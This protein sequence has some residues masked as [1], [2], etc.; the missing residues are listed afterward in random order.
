[1]AAQPDLAE[2]AD[3]NYVGSYR[4]LVEHSVAGAI[5][6]F[7]A[8]T[9]FTTGLPIGIFNGCIVVGPAEPA[10]LADSVR[11][12]A[13]LGVPYRVWIR[14]ELAG[15]LAPIPLGLGL[16]REAALYPGMVLRPAPVPPSPAPGVTVGPVVGRAALEEHLEVHVR[17]GLS[18]ELAK[19]MFSTAF[20]AD[21]DVRLFTAYLDGRPAGTSLAIRTGDASGV[22]NVGTLP[23]AR[24]RGV[25]AAATWAAVAAGREWGCDTIVLQSSEM[26]LSLYSA[27]GF[28]T[29]VSY[30]TFRP[31]LTVPG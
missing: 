9:A 11:W 23:D 26:G 30:A 28:R 27:M 21:P 10:D 14:E 17:K 13:G 7:G 29:V 5:R 15:G 12:V 16:E 2:I 22:Y 1:M 3:R 31:A 8:I 24:R 19:R 6:S 4:K 20:A 18:V 25:G